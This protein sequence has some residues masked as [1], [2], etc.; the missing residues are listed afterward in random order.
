MCF[1]P[2]SQE[3]IEHVARL[4]TESN[5]HTLI[6][7]RFVKGCKNTVQSVKWLLLGFDPERVAQWWLSAAFRNS[8]SGSDA[9]APMLAM[10]TPTRPIIVVTLSAGVYLHGPFEYP[11]T[12]AQR[13]KAIE[14]RGYLHSV[15]LA[16]LPWGWQVSLKAGSKRSRRFEEIPGDRWGLRRLAL[17]P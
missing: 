14:L 1:H 13:V 15:D 12:E 3:N 11:T 6:K 5:P 8:C 16:R 10:H 4:I 17:L 2:S 7:A 9:R